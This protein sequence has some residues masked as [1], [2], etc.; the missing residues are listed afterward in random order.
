[1]NKQPM[2]WTVNRIRTRII[3]TGMALLTVIGCAETRPFA[4]QQDANWINADPSGTVQAKPEETAPIK[5]KTHFAAGKMFEAQGMLNKAVLQY[6]KTLEL[7][8]EHLGALNRL[9][10]LY[11]RTGRHEEAEHLLKRAVRL[12]PRSA[13]VR[14]NL[15]FGYLLQE[16]WA[17]AEIEFLNVLEMMPEF[18]RARVNLGIALCRQSRF[19]EALAEFREV[20]PESDAFYNVGLMFRAQDRFADASRA[21]KRA[22]QLK[23]SF[24]AAKQQLAQIGPRLRRQDRNE[25]AMSE[26]QWQSLV[27]GGQAPANRVERTLRGY[28]G[29]PKP[30]TGAD[31]PLVEQPPV[32]QSSAQTASRT[33]QPIQQQPHQNRPSA[34]SANRSIY[35]QQ[36]STGAKQ[37]A[38]TARGSAMPSPEAQHPNASPVASRSTAPMMTDMQPVASSPPEGPVAVKPES[39]RPVAQKQPFEQ[40][41]A[42]QK[43]RA[44]SPQTFAAQSGGPLEPVSQTDEPA[45]SQSVVA[46]EDSMTPVEPSRTAV[47][48]EVKSLKQKRTQPVV[49]KQSQ[50]SQM[51]SMSPMT[52]DRKASPKSSP[53]RHQRKV[54][55]RQPQPSAPVASKGKNSARPIQSQSAQMTEMAP[56]ASA[57]PPAKA[58]QPKQHQQIDRPSRT[59]P[60]AK[61]A[62]APRSQP[63]AVQMSPMN[64]MAP[65]ASSNSPTSQPPAAKR[66]ARTA[67]HSPKAKPS[68]SVAPNK[69]RA[70]NREPQSAEPM[71]AMQPANGTAKKPKLRKP[72]TKRSE[73]AA[74]EM[75]PMQAATA[76]QKAEKEE[77]SKAD[78]KDKE[79]EDQM[80]DME[81]MTPSDD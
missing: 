6:K 60:V 28:A 58:S 44:E 12:A 5:P 54:A 7:D 66:T 51:E 56:M 74:Q 31:Q 75:T 29:A 50:P 2:R 23:P 48:A 52:S 59:R 40:P 16:R 76:P 62:P 45:D 42:P 47:P 21:F 39:Q 15:G 55:Q 18:E 33:Q 8:P 64:E 71:E 37:S 72:R 4:S 43:N 17:D 65:V 14:N 79:S 34:Q 30:Q 81:S 78:P 26:G 9:G 35:A 32:R 67:S 80:Q 38:R 20:V 19:D 53:V 22:I 11:A 61:A 25:I 70:N 49:A 24:L 27:A 3:I 73:P 10:I 69:F 1:M 77:S 68:P 41:T 13:Q 36:R 57:D 63:R 46:T